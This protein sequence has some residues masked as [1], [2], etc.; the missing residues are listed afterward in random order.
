MDSKQI[1]L[2]NDAK[3]RW[4][5]ERSMYSDYA[6]LVAVYK[7]IGIMCIATWL[8]IS[9]LILF[10]EGTSGVWEITKGFVIV[11]PIFAILTPLGFFFWA[12][13]RGGKYRELFEMSDKQIVHRQISRKVK[14][15]EVIGWLSVLTSVAALTGHVSPGVVSAS[16]GIRAH[17]KVK[18]KI[19]YKNVEKVIANRDKGIIKLCERVGH[20]DIY[21]N[22]QDFDFVY[23]FLLSHCQTNQK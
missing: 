15:S 22:S 21:V 9:L 12:F 6:S 14:D 18:T 7:G 17:T 13:I 11:I 20:H 2:G 4:V 1:Q 10:S 5:F 3:Y 23:D 16:H 19:Y 8:I